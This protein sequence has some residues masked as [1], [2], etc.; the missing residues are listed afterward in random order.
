ML[1]T[2]SNNAQEAFWA[3]S[4]S[5]NDYEYGVASDLDSQG[6]LFIIGYGTGPTVTLDTIPLRRI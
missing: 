2:K 3:K 6:N 1:F 5:S 4:V